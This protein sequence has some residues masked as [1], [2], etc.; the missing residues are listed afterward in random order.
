MGEWRRRQSGLGVSAHRATAGAVEQVV[1]ATAVALPA[2]GS[3]S[4]QVANAV[5]VLYPEDGEEWGWGSG[6]CE[7]E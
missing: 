1:Q 5:A 2:D 4:K 3:S 6:A 7:K